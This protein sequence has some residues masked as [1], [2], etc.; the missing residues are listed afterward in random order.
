[1]SRIIFN[2]DQDGLIFTIPSRKDA[3]VYQFISGIVG[4]Y[5]LIYVDY[6]LANGLVEEIRTGLSS[7][8]FYFILFVVLCNSFIFYGLWHILYL[9]FGEEIIRVSRFELI[10]YHKWK[11]FS[12]RRVFDLNK[13]SNFLSYLYTNTGKFRNN[14]AYFKIQFDYQKKVEKIGLELSEEEANMILEKINEFVLVPATSHI[15]S[16]NTSKEKEK[17]RYE[18][19]ALKPPVDLQFDK[20]GLNR[21][22]V[23]PKLICGFIMV[24]SFVFMM[25]SGSKNPTTNAPIFLITT[26]VLSLLGFSYSGNTRL[27]TF[28]RNNMYLP[29]VK[30]EE[31]VPLRQ[32]HYLKALFLPSYWVLFYTNNSGDEKFI[33]IN[34]IDENFSKF[35]ASVKESN[36]DFELNY[37]NNPLDTFIPDHLKSKVQAAS[38]WRLHKMIRIGILLFILFFILYDSFF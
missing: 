12:K 1:M 19:F 29:R 6:F 7:T 21:K 38:Y 35:T 15:N 18:P 33:I 14:R 27:I 37:T 24:Y 17:S 9:L 16:K 4:L 34:S 13:A 2:E 25:I 3:I 10:T 8:L 11:L 31:V 22:M 5:V 36:S 30:D 32:V 20:M 23:L 28:D 26:F